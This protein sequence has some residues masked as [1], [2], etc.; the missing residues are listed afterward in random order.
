[1]EIL[2]SQS[3]TLLTVSKIEGG[4]KITS[5]RP[6]PSYLKELNIGMVSPLLF[7]KMGTVPVGHSTIGSCL[8]ESHTCGGDPICSPGGKELGFICVTSKIV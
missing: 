4:A 5:A 3:F 6:L 2:A 1:M 7:C 8:F